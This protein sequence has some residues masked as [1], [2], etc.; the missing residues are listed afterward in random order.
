MKLRTISTLAFT[1]VAVLAFAG[2]AQAAKGAK[3]GKGLR[4]KIVSVAADGSSMV[5]KPAHK[6]NAKNA[7]A[8]AAAAT[9]PVTV[10]FAAGCTVT[11]NGT[12]GTIAQLAAGDSVSVSPATGAATEIKA[13]IGG[14][15]KG[16]KKAA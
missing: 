4:G 12:P 9:D 3:A 10:T 6:K 1:L 14:K 15:G 11:I 13:K 8:G 16:K 7:A 5:V 2:V